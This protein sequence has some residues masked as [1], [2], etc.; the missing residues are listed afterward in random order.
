[1]DKRLINAVDFNELA[2]KQQV[3]SDLLSFLSNPSSLSLQLKPLPL[4]SSDKTIICDVSTKVPRPFVPKSFH[5]HTFSKLH[6]LS[7]PGIRA[8]QQLISSRF[9]WPHMQK[10][11]QQWLQSCLSCQRSKI[12]LHTVT[13]LGLFL[14]P[15]SHFDGIHID[16]VGPLPPSKGY[17]FLLTIID[18]FTHWPEAISLADITAA[19]HLLPIGY[20]VLAFQPQ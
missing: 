15:D 3:D 7:H 9:V 18:R 17:S 5:R 13:P 10:D 2:D 8:T 12:Q 11:I 19:S 16:L 14:P 6:S 1:M 4:P 20:L